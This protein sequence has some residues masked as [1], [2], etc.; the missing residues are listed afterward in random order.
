MRNLIP[1]LAILLLACSQ[2]E[3][4]RTLKGVDEALNESDQ[5][6]TTGEVSAGLKEAL[7]KG[8]GYA[9]DLSGVKD[10]FYKNPRLF[11]PFPPEAEKVKETALQLGLDN[12]VD[13][14]EETLNRA[15]EKAVQEAQPIF[16]DAITSM[17]VEDAF[18]LLKGG[19]NA[20]TEYLRRK[21]GD[22]LFSKF[23]PEVSKAVNAVQLTQYYS[24]L[25]GAY[26]TSTTFTGGE[27][28]NPD[29]TK[30][31]TEQSID[32]LFKLIA[33]EEE[34]IREDPAARVTDLLKKVFGSS[35]AQ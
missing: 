27:P 6:L 10:G 1:F 15:A 26:N 33:D 25:A 28:I 20:A 16:V 35:A 9:V 21:T 24:P 32:G 19:E 29:L 23:E 22:Q 2:Q 34:K 18:G 17:S 8:T 30:Y 14:F 7:V 13:Q 31:V 12:Q 3:I 11:I 4:Q 5:N